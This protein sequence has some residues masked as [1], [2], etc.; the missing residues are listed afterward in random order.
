MFR[1]FI[2]TVRGAAFFVPQGL[3]VQEAA[4][5]ALGGL[6]GVPPGI[7]L[8]ISLATRVRELIESI[9]GL[10]MWQRLEGKTLRALFSNGKQPK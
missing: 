8:S 10:L 6:V 2:A 1:S 4:F 3:G 7:A 5:I 9:A